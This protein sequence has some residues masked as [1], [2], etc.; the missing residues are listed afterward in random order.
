MNDDLTFASSGVAGVHYAKCWSCQM[1]ADS[2][3]FDPPRWHSW[4]DE[5][6]VDHARETGQ[7]DPRDKRCACW[8]A[9]AGK[10][11]STTGQET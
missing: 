3:H 8:C 5:D 10:A 4:A 7:P 6:D 9:E 2:Q 1:G 11:G